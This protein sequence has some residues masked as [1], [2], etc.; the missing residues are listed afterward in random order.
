MAIIDR[1]TPNASVR[2]ANLL[3]LFPQWEWLGLLSPMPMFFV[4]A[5]WANSQ[6]S[7]SHRAHRLRV[8]TGAA[9]VVV[10][11]W[12]LLSLGELLISGHSD[13][14]GDGARI[15]TQPLWFLAAYLPF[16]AASG[17]IE[18]LSQRIPLAITLCLLLVSASDIARLILGAPRW[19]GYPGFFATWLI[20][21]TLGAWWRHASESTVI[22]ER[23]SGVALA[24]F[25]LFMSM[26]LVTFAGYTPSLIDAI[27]GHRSNTTPP[28]LF[29]CTAAICQVGIL[30]LLA[31]RLDGLARRWEDA[32]RRLNALSLGVY[33][34]HLT[35][36]VL[37]AGLF[38]L[39]A[40]VAERFS[41]TWW[42]LRVPWFAAISA[43]AF[44]LVRATEMSQSHLTHNPTTKSSTYMSAKI[45]I[46]LATCGATITGL[47]GPRTLPSAVAMM[48]S[49]VVGWLLQ[50]EQAN[51]LS[52]GVEK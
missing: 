45:G 35:A 37:T 32:L 30:M 7:V 10:T 33:M 47:Y 44:F 18:K 14:L 31:T 8:L 50:G 24:A 1:P 23:R 49:F 43:I 2:G 19:V 38:A 26:I 28:T 22:H 27:P 21:W 20:P 12:S 36:V 9:A 52:S 51:S 11:A 39:V 41:T 15:A 25:G 42:L 16:T 46:F 4:A 48:G 17:L 13:I 5:G 3:A 34:W 6:S 29:T 40:P